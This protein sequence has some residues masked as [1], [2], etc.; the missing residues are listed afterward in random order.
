MIGAMVTIG[1]FGA[2]GHLGRSLAAR[3]N[4]IKPASVSISGTVDKEHNRELAMHTDLAI[5][6][7]RPHDI[8]ALLTDIKGSLK[9]NMQVLSFAA[10]ISIRDIAH[11]VGRPVARGMA[12]PWWNFAGFVYG[13]NFSTNGY[14]FL[15]DNLGK[16]IIPLEDESGINAFTAYF[17]HAYIVLFLKELGELRNADAH[18]SYLAP[19][20]R[21]SVEE[22]TR[23]L[24]EGDPAELLKKLAT[25]GGVTEAILLAIR[26]DTNISP[27]AAH[28]AGM[29]RIQKLK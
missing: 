1:I 12:D 16:N 2:Q 22:L 18:L 7:V 17:V 11:I 9:P 8:A 5:I 28:A 6:A 3:L 21:T 27:D 15:F 10:G 26:N 29:E 25:P 14:Q 23:C 19:H 4:N 24:P 20:L 13:E